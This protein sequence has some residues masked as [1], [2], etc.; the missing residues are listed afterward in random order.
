VPQA[1][2]DD[3]M[4][5]YAAPGGGVGP[6]FDSYDVFLIQGSGRRR[7]RLMRPQGRPF[8]VVPG[9]PLK[10]IANFRAQ[11]E[12][13]AEP[14]DLLYLPPGWGHDGVALDPCLTYSVGFRAPAG[15][16]LAAA[17]LDHLHE[18]GLP[19]ASY[20]DPGLRPARHPARISGDLLDYAERQLGRIR[21]Q[22]RDVAD[23]LGRFLSS[24]KPNVVFRGGKSRGR[25]AV[26]DPRT[27]LLYD[28]E[29]FFINGESFV[30]RAGQRAALAKLAD[31]RSAPAS[32]LMRAGLGGQL[33]D[34]QRAGFLHLREAA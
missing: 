30:P 20:R 32:A 4:L 21:W 25:L 31:R 19:D 11:E 33:R 2:L 5:S 23:F 27:Q 1:R 3:V 15:A 12:I 24:P 10:L 17:F 14:G 28:G 7:W 16:E 22:R 34:W 8:P 6:H 13:L 18:R 29:R 9:A 26:L